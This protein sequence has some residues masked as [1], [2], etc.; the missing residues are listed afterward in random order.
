MNI[1]LGG[2]IQ[3]SAVLLGCPHLQSSYAWGH[4]KKGARKRTE[5]VFENRAQ[6]TRGGVSPSG[7]SEDMVRAVGGAR[8]LLL[9]ISKEFL[10][11]CPERGCEGH[12]GKMMKPAV[13]D[14]LS[15]GDRKGVSKM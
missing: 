7:G 6:K 1:F 2:F 15:T 12:F 3:K 14:P 4:F 10:R 9:I 5:L 13:Q 11:T 8:S